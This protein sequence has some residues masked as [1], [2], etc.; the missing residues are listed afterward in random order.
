VSPANPQ[1]WNAYAYVGDTPLQATDP[2]GLMTTPDP[3]ALYTESQD[4]VLEAT[5]G[6]EGGENEFTLQSIPV[7]YIGAQPD[8]IFFFT[9]VSA[10]FLGHVSETVRIYW[11]LDP[12]IIGNGAI[13]FGGPNAAGVQPGPDVFGAQASPQTPAIGPYKPPLPPQPEQVTPGCMAAALI[14]NFVGDDAHAGVTLTVNIG[15]AVALKLVEQTGPGDLLPGPG[16]LYAG[17]AVL[18]D[19][20]MVAK[21]YLDCRNGG[22]SAQ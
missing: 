13:L 18:W 11:T 1:S 20:G 17:V 19:A 6:F 21:S 5:Q 16:W 12:S 15:A 14:H 3:S 8:P 9:D 10:D 4:D 2:L 22:P 7:R